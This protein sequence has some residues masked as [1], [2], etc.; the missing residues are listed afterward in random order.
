M[1]HKKIL[2]VLFVLLMLFSIYPVSAEIPT[3]DKETIYV[4]QKYTISYLNETD[5]PVC[6]LIIT[7]SK[8]NESENL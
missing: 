6:Y 8:S 1:N 7:S 5:N 4:G 2:S 3:T